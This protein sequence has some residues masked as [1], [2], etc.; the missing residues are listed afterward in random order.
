M[1]VAVLAVASFTVAQKKPLDHSVYDGWRSIASPSLTRD[2]RFAGYIYRPQEGDSEA[3]FRNLATNKIVSVPRLSNFS[4]T[5]DSKFAV[6]TQVPPFIE[7]RDARRKRVPAADQPKNNLII[8]NLETGDVKEIPRVTS[9]SIAENDLGFI[10][11]RPEPPRPEPNRP[12]TPPTAT[13]AGATTPPTA[14][15]TPKKKADH[16]AGDANVL[17]EVAT[18]KETKLADIASSRWSEDGSTLLL[19]ISTRDGAKDGVVRL[20]VK[21][22]RSQEIVTGLGRYNRLAT[23]EN[24]NVV[25]FATDKA[26]YAAKRPVWTAHVWTPSGGLKTIP[27]PTN[28]NGW[29]VNENGGITVSDS[30]RRVVFGIG[31]KTPDDIETPEDERVN[32]DVWNWM[33]DVLM[34]QQLIQV[35]A[36]R[37]RTYDV[38]F[39]VASGTSRGIEDQ[40]IRAVSIRTDRDTPFGLAQ[41]MKRHNR[42]MSWDGVYV[43]IVLVDLGTGARTMVAEKVRGNADMSP[44]TNWTV[45]LDEENKRLYSYDNRTKTRRDLTAAVPTS[46]FDLETDV[47]D[48]PNAFGFSGWLKDESRFAVSDGFDIWL[49]DPT[50]QAR[51]ENLTRGRLLGLRFRAVNLDPENPNTIQREGQLYAAQSDRTKENGIYR[52]TARGLETL[53]QGPKS[54]GISAKARDADVVLATQQDCIEFP[55]LWTTNTS[56]QNLKKITDANPQQ[57]QY[58]WYTSELVTWRSGDGTPLQGILIKPENFDYRKKYPMITYF[59][60]R[61]S[62]TLFNYRAPAPSASVINIPLFASNEY[63]IFIPDIPYKIGYPGESAVSAI[64]SGVNSVLERGY[65]DPKRVGIQG[66]SWG[67]YQV[68]YLITETDMFAAAEAGAPVSNMISAYGGI[69]YGSGLVRQ[70]QYERQQS[71]IGGTPWNSFLRYVENSP[72][73]FADKVKT[74]LMIMHNDRDGAVPYTQS[75]EFFTALR[76]LNK[77][78]W[79]V[80]YNEEDHNLIQRKNRKD[81]SIRLSQF[82]D[83]FLKG[84]PMPEWMAKGIP[85]VDKGRNM[86]TNLVPPKR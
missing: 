36:E 61:S 8:V 78:V 47:P 2:G 21:S 46:L 66:Q 44:S 58:N 72:I 52:S 25:A 82:F 24:G 79:M 49:V 43:D 67:G 60:D 27:V 14:A 81:L 85:A 4:F 75:I 62:D 23:S 55:D 42:L 50:G 13:P 41:E 65:V 9:F 20:D 30:G 69:R 54:Y 77:P 29:I 31:P 39:D 37:T 63:V 84:A 35:N 10:L 7:A 56:L 1:S 11:Y 17:L 15:N 40:D 86:G 28:P 18:G 59:Y 51:S 45:L 22:G 71:R 73:F 3:Q 80:V 76:R 83:H 53:I 5:A 6:G 48:F 64:V 32:V 16:R 38:L 33:D 57:A 19:S 26:D 74:P 12:A 68:S 34:S 70:F